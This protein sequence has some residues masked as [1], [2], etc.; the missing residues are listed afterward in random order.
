MPI[1]FSYLQG[2]PVRDASGKLVGRLKDLVV[3]QGDTH[4]PDV[5]GVVLK[6][7]AYLPMD[8]VALMEQREV[9]LH[10]DAPMLTETPPEDQLQLARDLL[11]AQ[12]VDTT[13]AKV[14]RVNDI[15]LTPSKYILFVS[16]LDIGVWGLMR[17]L[18][19]AAPFAH[20]VKLLGLKVGEGIIP[21]HTTEPIHK[22][23]TRLHLRVA[24]D[25]LARMHP[26]DLAE[27]IEELG[28][29]QRTRLFAE[30]TDEQLADLIEESEPDMQS[31]ILLELEPERAADV[32]EE[33][34]PDEAADAL[35]ELDER[36]AEA[37]IGL[38]EP[39]EAAEVQQLLTYED[40]TAGG[41]MTTS[42]LAVPEDTPISGAI[43]M[44]RAAHPDAE[45][46]SYFYLT[47]NE[48]RL[49]GVVSVRRLLLQ[50]DHSVALVYLASDAL[51]SVKP[52]TAADEVVELIGRYELAALPVV[53]EIGR[54]VG[55]V[56]VHDALDHLQSKSP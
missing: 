5:V 47:D 35:G 36:E 21:W 30:L 20:L 40:E 12:V 22:D 27:I 14:V 42:F 25:R 46:I 48:G 44:F 4:M 31:A 6:G 3:H 26:A 43:A 28:Y 56:T 41:L 34:E 13:G 51:Y 1:F 9:R 53:D 23:P 17:R 19:W 38:M 7:N 24:Q 2:A 52:D 39:R 54:I 29:H 18:G 11:D 8:K 10:V 33:M 37:L 15:L 55:V 32:L 16:G 49:S 45:V 50:E